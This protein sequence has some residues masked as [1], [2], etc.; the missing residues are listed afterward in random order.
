MHVGRSDGPDARRPM[1]RLADGSA[2]GACSAD[3]LVC[4]TYVHGLF[5]HDAQRGAWLAR[6]GAAPSGLV[7]EARIEAALDELA[8][9]VERHM[10]IDRLL[11]LAR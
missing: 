8:A 6:W 1:L 5:A 7:H 2:E 11:S 4:G 10:R 9:H 3:G